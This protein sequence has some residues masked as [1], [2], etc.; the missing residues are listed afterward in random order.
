MARVRCKYC[1][2][3]VDTSKQQRPC[4]HGKRG[5]DHVLGGGA[6]ALYDAVHK[7]EEVKEHKP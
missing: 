2:E 6:A 3:V 7:A 1:K 4:P 5:E